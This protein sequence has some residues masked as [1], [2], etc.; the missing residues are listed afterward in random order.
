MLNRLKRLYPAYIIGLLLA[1]SFSALTFKIVLGN[2]FFL[3]TLQSFIVPVPEF[4][5]PVWYLAF[6]MFFYC[7]YALYI[8]TDHSK[9]FM[10]SWIGISLLCIPLYYFPLGG[11]P[12]HF[13]AMFAFSSIWLLGYHL[14]LY[15]S[16]FPRVTLRQAVFLFGMLL[17]SARIEYSN[18]YFCIIK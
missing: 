12:G 17:L 15:I 2:L 1:F 13:I 16:Q 10:W 3:G 8:K 5:P 18:Q 7:M 4:N 11:I 6:E 9:V 14:S